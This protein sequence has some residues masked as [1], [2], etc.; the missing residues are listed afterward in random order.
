[1]KSSCHRPRIALCLLV[2]GL[3]WRCPADL[4]EVKTV[5]LIVMENHNWSSI[6]ETNR[7]PYINQLLLPRAAF[8]ENYYNPTNLHP[9]EPNYLWLVA[10]TNFGIKDDLSP[11]VNALN[12]T[13]QL[14]YQ[15]DRAGIPWRT[16]QEDISGTTIPRTND[17]NYAVR[18]NPFMFFNNIGTNFAYCTN[19]VRPFTELATDLAAGRVAR[20]NFITPNLTNDMHNLTPGSPSTRVQGDNWLRATLGTILG[21]AAYQDRGAVFITWDEGVEDAAPGV[22]RDGPIGLMVVSPLGKGGGYHNSLYYT[23]SSTLRTFQEIFAVRPFLGDAANATDLADLFQPAPV[24][25]LSLPANS[26]SPPLIF[27]A[28]GA[29]PGRTYE[30][31]ASTD[32]Q[33]WSE[34]H[35]FVATEAALTLPAQDI[36]AGGSRYYRLFSP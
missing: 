35:R 15:L 32:L 7:C 10:G 28:A 29:E 2:W 9:S 23:H 34:V 20:F 33:V 17:G 12:T 27:R 30:L 24:L 3:V 21:S 6:R 25:Q 31:Q 18:H 19:H 36:L 26:A 8:A 16:Y 13:N 14:A 4:P 1:M 11:S 22:A 5:F